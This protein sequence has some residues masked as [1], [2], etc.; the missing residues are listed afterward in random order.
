MTDQ[1][2]RGL[3]QRL[4]YVENRNGGLI[5]GS[6]ARIGWVS[7]SK[8]GK[9]VYYRGL[10]LASIG[11]SGISGNFMDVETA[12]NTGSQASR[13]AARTTTPKKEASAPRSMRT[14]WTPI[15]PCE[16]TARARG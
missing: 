2:T 4:M 3:P 13:N 14:L 12:R 15:S 6:P 8:T 16:R 5:D 11:G 9:T 10:E 1:R 7:F